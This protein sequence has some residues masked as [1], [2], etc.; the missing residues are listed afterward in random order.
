[1]FRYFSKHRHRFQLVLE[2]GKSEEKQLVQI[3]RRL[4]DREESI[5]VAGYTNSL[6][7]LSYNN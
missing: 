2:H 3:V 6:P 7:E 4:C 5:R 1:M